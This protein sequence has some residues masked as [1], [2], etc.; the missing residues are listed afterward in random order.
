[1]AVRQGVAEEALLR[2][3]GL[4]IKHENETMVLPA[5]KLKTLVAGK[6]KERFPDY[7]GKRRPE[8]LIYFSWRPGV[9]Q[10]ALL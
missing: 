7:Y 1:M 3:E 5:K 4:I 10:E 2:N 9:K 8:H 6:S